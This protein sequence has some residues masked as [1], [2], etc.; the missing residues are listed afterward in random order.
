MSDRNRAKLLINKYDAENGKEEVNQIL[1]Q[2]SYFGVGR[3]M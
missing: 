3:F 2:T 1:F